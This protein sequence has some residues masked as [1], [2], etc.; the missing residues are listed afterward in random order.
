MASF[1]PLAFMRDVFERQKQLAQ[2]C[3]DVCPECG[4]HR[5]GDARVKAGMKCG[6]CA[7]AYLPDDDWDE[8]REML[9]EIR[10]D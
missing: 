5:P 3:A 8:A 7:Y 4:N 10:Y 2:E 9:D 1:D 6:L